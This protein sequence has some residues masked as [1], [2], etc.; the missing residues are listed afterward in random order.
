[1]IFTR[2][3]QLD[4]VY[5]RRVPRLLHDRHSVRGLFG[6]RS[7]AR[8]SI[9]TLLPPAGHDVCTFKCK[10][11]GAQTLTPVTDANFR[12]STI[13]GEF[14]KAQT[15]LVGKALI[16]TDGKART[17]LKARSVKRMFARDRFR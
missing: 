17:V 4:H 10:H 16:L 6:G 2:L 11:R 5:R 15:V 13:F 3:G 1:M 9:D 7:S 12:A 8:S 14:E